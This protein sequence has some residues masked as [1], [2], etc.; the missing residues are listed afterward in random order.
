MGDYNHQ[1]HPT[2]WLITML[3]K[4]QSHASF[5]QHA[6]LQF[7]NLYKPSLALPVRTEQNELPAP[8][9]NTSTKKTQRMETAEKL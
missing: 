5:Q 8:P 3:T 4:V 6:T 2:S 9:A 1:H 7:L